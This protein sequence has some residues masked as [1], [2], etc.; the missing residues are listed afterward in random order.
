M[1]FQPLT[2]GSLSVTSIDPA[3]LIPD[4]LEAWQE[5]ATQQ[6]A[7]ANPFLDPAWV[8]HWYEAFTDPGDRMLLRVHDVATGG[9][10]GVAPMHRQRLRVGPVGLAARL[11]PVGAGVGPNPFEIPGVL[12]APG[13]ARD[14]MRPLVA[15]TLA[16]GS[17]WCELAMTQEQ[18]WFEPEWLYE[19]ELPVTFGD[20]QRPRACV[21]LPL[22]ST[23]DDTRRGLKRNLKESIRRSANRLAK[24][25]RPWQVVHL[26]DDLDTEAVDRFL[27]LHQ[28]RS[29][30]ERSTVRH[31]DAYSDPRAR[32]LMRTALPE[33]GRKGM[34]SIF[35]LHLDGEVVAAQLALHMPGVSYVHSSGFDQAEW[36]LGPVTFLQAELVKY[37]IA[38][39]DT[40]V[41]FSPGPNVSKLRWSRKLWVTHEFAYGCGPRSL[42]LRY[43]TYQ[44]LSSLRA[45][46]TAVRFVRQNARAKRRDVSAK[47][48]PAAVT[49][50]VDPIVQKDPTPQQQVRPSA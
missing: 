39:K 21:I 31:P 17:D 12:T 40:V 41:N 3:E 14:V 49:F 45:N 42:Q 47:T 15:A 44:T 37:A 16:N 19:T 28:R 2:V 29:A 46:A 22:E 48:V 9:L 10:L 36:S 38:R 34:A 8:L 25:G 18:G 26:T 32:D 1:A 35:E 6:A 33:L 30:N 4:D 50:T 5:L 13:T 23:W 7:P 43:A 27:G 20:H 24:D 11:M